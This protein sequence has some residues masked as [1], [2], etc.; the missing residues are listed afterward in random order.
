MDNIHVLT[1]VHVSNVNERSIDARLH[2]AY[3]M[4]SKEKYAKVMDYLL[5]TIWFLSQ[6]ACTEWISHVIDVLN[7]AMLE[8]AKCRY[9]KVHDMI[10]DLHFYIISE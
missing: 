8:C 6:V 10:R 3:K 2:R 9:S 1:N 5:A 7:V 4:L